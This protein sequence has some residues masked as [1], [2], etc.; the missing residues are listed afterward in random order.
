MRRMIDYPKD[1]RL[2]A[3]QFKGLTKNYQFRK[4]VESAKKFLEDTT[5]DDEDTTFDDQLL[6]HDQSSTT[7]L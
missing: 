5:F 1:R 7:D 3:S 6:I 2:L 4:S